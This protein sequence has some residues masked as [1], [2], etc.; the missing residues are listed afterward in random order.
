MKREREYDLV[1]GL[2]REKPALEQGF[3][4]RDHTSLAR[5]RKFFDRRDLGLEALPG[6]GRDIVVNRR[7]GGRDHEKE[8]DDEGENCFPQCR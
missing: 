1:I 4:D 8:A 6:Q 7:E 5:S 3:Q 2:A